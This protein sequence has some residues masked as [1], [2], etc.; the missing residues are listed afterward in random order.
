MKRQQRDVYQLKQVFK[1]TFS[2][3]RG[4]IFSP[5]VIFSLSIMCVHETLICF[6]CASLLL[7]LSPVPDFMW[8]VSTD[9][10]EVL[11]HA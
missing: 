8:H 1:A 3:I 11:S 10:E 7:S 4:V 9:H 5:D 6:V 2:L